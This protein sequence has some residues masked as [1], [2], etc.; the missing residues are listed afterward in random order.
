MTDR[1][2]KELE[3]LGLSDLHCLLAEHDIEPEFL[4]DL[5]DDNLREIG[6]SLG[7]I[8]RFR[9]GLKSLF[10][11]ADGQPGGRPTSERRQLTALF[12]DLVGSTR[13]AT[14]LDP[15]DL[16]DVMQTYQRA[17]AEIIASHCGHV[18]YLQGDGLMAYFGFPVAGEDDPERAIR[19][20]LSL[21]DRISTLK[22]AATGGLAVRVG[23]ASGIVVVG[24]DEDSAAATEIVVGETPNLAARLQ[25]VA[26]PGEVII[27]ESTRRLGRAMFEVE[28]RGALD[29]KGFSEPMTVYRVVEESAA[30][31]RFEA[32]ATG[33]L[34]AIVGREAELRH[35]RR[36]WRAA[37]GGEG[38]IAVISGEAG[39]GKSRL[40]RAFIETLPLEGQHIIKW[41][42]AAHLANR[43]LHPVVREIEKAAGIT[44][45]M[46]DDMRRAAL[47]AHVARFST[48]P[49]DSLLWLTDLLGLHGLNR[50]DL[51]A[52]ARAKLLNEALLNRVNAFASQSPTLILLEDAHWA[53]A[54]TL[55][56]LTALVPR[57][58]TASVMLLVTHR[59]EFVPPWQLDDA[60]AGIMLRGIDQA[61]G[62]RLLSMVA[63]GRKLPHAV[64]RMIL[65]K[66]GGVPL[67][68]EELTKTVLDSISDGVAVMQGDGHSSIP[69]T[70]QDS[71]MARLDRLGT[72]K[73]LAQLGSVIGRE[74]TAD[75]LRII[76]P[77]HTDIE[78]DLRRLCASG[79]AFE[80]SGS[81]SG[82]IAFHHALIQ[83]AAYEALLKKRR[84]DVHRAIAEAMLAGNDAFAGAEPETIAR[85]SARGGLHEAATRHWLVAG[86]NAL[87]RAAN[88]PAHAHLT[89]ALEHLELLP[90]TDERDATELRIQMALA[91]TIMSLRGW[92]DNGVE[93]ASKRARELAIR[94]GDR[95]AE[96]GAA[97]GVWTNS[98]LR[99]DLHAGLAAAR[100]VEAIAVADQTALSA[101]G[102]AH[103]LC[104]SYYSRGEFTD[105]LT[106][107]KSGML[108]YDADEDAVGLRTFQ[109][110]PSTAML[111]VVSNALWFL[112]DTAAA[113]QMLIDA[114]ARAESLKHM[115]V[116]AHTLCV[117]SF[118]LLFRE[119]WARL[120]P[121]A[122]RALAISE[123]E[124]F[125][126]WA[127]MAG[128]YLTFARQPDLDT[129]AT[130]AV[131]FIDAF[132]GLGY[133]L[134]L[135]QFEAALGKVLILKGEADRAERRLSLSIENARSRAER[136]YMPEALRVRGE[137]R[138]L[139]GDRAAAW[140]DFAEARTMAL[141]QG[142]VPLVS[143]IERSLAG[144]QERNSEMTTV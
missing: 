142:A 43:P 38:G 76:A 64:A 19:A 115:P 144:L 13:L 95:G 127:P 63:D 101:L 141:R 10:T 123:A 39:I 22:T 129:I 85:H 132:G 125:A 118:S 96:M 26:A 113:D 48:A 90:E 58:A 108:R 57:L 27:A 139:L 60:R 8:M 32:Q 124:G 2:F 122:A 31:S 109:L 67:F 55:E 36:V 56:L 51:D 7:Q 15:E 29:L 99:G 136:C 130:A 44:R 20:G 140:E 75:M 68:V 9:R 74:F 97:W 66:A 72:A 5:S 37:L 3:R 73:E 21:C 35:L 102:A 119:D 80:R 86:L 41:H 70:L 94:V 89:A 120:E 77:R 69:A 40:A 42:C 138:R 126:F 4:G 62:E 16:R 59:P 18:A 53:D 93:R 14:E 65:E 82:M 91:P 100:D 25:Q 135:S 137:A 87:D 34:H 104:F 133:N 49:D 117:S 112:G 23:I 92:A 52:T 6:L 81:V 61:A 71:L 78:D 54:A 121:I 50:P 134:T 110:S 12:C 88:Q 103:A 30:P 98:Y 128:V 143:R 111:T 1:L 24:I 47:E 84:R 116:L 17:C 83:D 114:H 79:L 45:V 33:G 106:A 131:G 11:R 107:M 105:A 28:H 46:T